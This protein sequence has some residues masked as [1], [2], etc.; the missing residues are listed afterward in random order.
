MESRSV[1]LDIPLG[2][3]EGHMALPSVGQAAMLADQLALLIARTSPRSIAIAGCAGGNGLERVGPPVERVVAIDI[4]PAYLD[5]VRA[6]HAHRVRGLELHCGD[7]QSPVLSFEPVDLIFAG[8]IFEYVDPMPAL[9]TFRRN[10]R[11]AAVLVALLQ[12]PTG[13]HEAISPSPFRT[14]GKL[15]GEMRLVDPAELERAATAAGFISED[16]RVI[17][18]ASGKRFHLRIFVARR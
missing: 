7:V 8:L 5:A 10:A 9:A 4:N 16:S 15:A 6:R 1:W 3:Y 14:L 12:L 18:L 13:G 17:G 11:P 2:D